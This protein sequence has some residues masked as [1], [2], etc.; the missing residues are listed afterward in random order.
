MVHT[1]TTVYNVDF[2]T[3]STQTGIKDFLQGLQLTEE[4]PSLF[5]PSSNRV[6]ESKVS[7]FR[8][9]QMKMNYE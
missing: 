8:I 5:N 9:Q 1:E 6:H 4:F 7:A 2:S 3:S